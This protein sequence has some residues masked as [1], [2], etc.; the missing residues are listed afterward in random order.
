M[1]RF[2]LT[3]QPV[4]T[5]LAIVALAII[6]YSRSSSLAENGTQAPAK[7]DAAAPESP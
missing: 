7:G 4:S 3:A 6:G 2:R 5:A 1:I